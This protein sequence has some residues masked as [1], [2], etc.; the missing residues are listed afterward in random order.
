MFDIHTLAAYPEAPFALADGGYF[1]PSEHWYLSITS[2]RGTKVMH[3]HDTRGGDHNGEMI[4]VEGHGDFNTMHDALD[5]MDA[6]VGEAEERRHY[7]RGF[8]PVAEW[9]TSGR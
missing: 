1:I 8:D 5:H 4:Q 9:G 7:P 3:G 6:F 2:Y